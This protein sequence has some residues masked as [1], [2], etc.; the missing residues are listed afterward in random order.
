MASIKTVIDKDG[1]ER[2]QVRVRIK[3]HAPQFATFTRITDAKKWA[4]QTE[5]AIEEGRFF[6]T[7]EA[8][9][10]TLA[11]AI[12]RYIKTVLPTEPK[13]AG[14]SAYFL[15]NGEGKQRCDKFGFARK[16]QT[17]NLLFLSSGEIGLS[18]LIRQT[19]QKVRAGHEVR[20]ID[21]PAFTDH[22]GVC[23]SLI[24]SKLFFQATTHH[25]R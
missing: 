19:G 21:L 4:Q 5:S 25:D 9:K 12:D 22:Y 18:D 2:H 24:I 10:H 15:A 3:G 17:W 20:V 13:I 16:K 11:D 23:G 7:N 1:K 14:E 6:K 8:R